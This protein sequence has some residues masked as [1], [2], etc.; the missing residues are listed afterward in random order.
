MAT[1]AHW[2]ELLQ[3]PVELLS[4]LANTRAQAQASLPLHLWIH[5]CPQ[6]N[7]AA[8][9]AGLQQRLAESTDPATLLQRYPLLGVPFAVKDNIDI[10][11][12]PT[13]AAC[14]SF[15]HTATQSATVVR[16]LLEAGALWLGKTNLDQFATGLVG[17]R[18]PHGRP[19]SVADASRISGGSSS[20]SALAVARGIVPIALGTDTAGSGRVPA[21]FNGLVGL[22]P[23]P[24]RV[25]TA[26]V[27]PACRTLDC[28]SIFAHTVGDAAL[29][30]AVIEGA[31]SADAYSH[32]QPGPAQAAR[33]LR[34]G[35]PK[36][37]DLD[38]HCGYPAAWLAASIHALH[39]GHELVEIDFDLLREVAALLYEGP[40]VAERHAA[41]RDLFHHSPEALDT[42]VRRVIARATEFSATDAFEAQYRLRELQAHLHGLWQGVDALLVPTAPTHPSFAEVDADPIGVNARLGTF[43]NFVNL[44]GWCALAVPA[45]PTSSGLPFGVTFIAPGGHDVALQEVARQWL[46]EAPSAP[47]RRPAVQ[48]ML[49]L[50]VVGAHL[51]GLPLNGQLIERGAVLLEATTTAVHYRFY[52]LPGTTPPKPGLQRVAE[53]GAAIAVEVWAVPQAA[54]GSFLAL[55]PAPL[56]LGTLELADG[57][58]VHGFLCE[59]HALAG[60]TDITAFGG[61]R[62]YLASRA[63]EPLAN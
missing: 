4:A 59:A 7:W 23:T 8:Q 51:S 28:V 43:T 33:P 24:G 27:L 30:L 55:I 2:R 63:A 29:V 45:A 38:A 32:F 54:I 10:A 21:G 60:A 56:G 6:D 42:T 36:A 35:V 41:C 53:G 58:H 15:T 3:K 20:G 57:R 19:S 46:G 18:S 40:W 16:K 11:D 48:P 12:E 61:W 5:L 37:P 22:K 1:L 9:L 44:L 34:L 62:A 49:P 47:L 25:S 39:C 17:T 26:G 52:A 13:S 31:D 50:A 14:P